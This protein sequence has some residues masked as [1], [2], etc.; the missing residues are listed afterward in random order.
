MTGKEHRHC[1]EE[2]CTTWKMRNSV[3]SSPFLRQ[4]PKRSPPRTQKGA[5]MLR[6]AAGT[7]K[8]PEHLCINS[9]PKQAV[10]VV[11][12]L[13]FHTAWGHKAVT[14]QPR[15]LY[16]QNKPGRPFPELSPAGGSRQVRNR[17]KSHGYIAKKPCLRL[18]PNRNLWM[19]QGDKSKKKTMV[20]VGLPLSGYSQDLILSFLQA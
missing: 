4:L 13:F 5:N 20:H 14:G 15:C 11:A 16:F 3:M 1:E 2:V 19:T 12:K 7:L 9:K 18:A 8:T 17:E 10:S 6:S